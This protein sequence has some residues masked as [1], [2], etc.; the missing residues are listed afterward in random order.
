MGSLPNLLDFPDIEETVV[1]GANKQHHK[2]VRLVTLDRLGTSY[3]LVRLTDQ[4]SLML[5]LDTHLENGVLVRRRDDAF[6][7]AQSQL[8][9]MRPLLTRYGG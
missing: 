9:A 1:L 4:D 3:T 2:V 8:F 7:P 5:E 6:L